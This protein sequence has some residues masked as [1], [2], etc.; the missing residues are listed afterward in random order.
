[1]EAIAEKTLASTITLTAARGPWQVCSFGFHN[2]S[3]TGA[4]VFNYIY[5]ESEPEDED[6][7][8]VR[9]QRIG[10]LRYTKSIY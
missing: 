6:A 2:R 9:L 7:V 8:R 10:R 4:R 3:R 5:S 1:M